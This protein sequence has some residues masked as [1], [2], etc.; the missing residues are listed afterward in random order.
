MSNSITRSGNKIYVKEAPKEVVKPATSGD[1]SEPSDTSIDSLLN[2][3][4]QQI[5]GL[6][7]SI[8][9]EVNMGTASR[10]TV[11]NLKDIMTLLLELKKKEKEFLDDMTD[12]ELERL[13][14]NANK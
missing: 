12:D 14:K 10:E 1:T 4:L 13:A 8:T 2:C 5:K 7:R 11:Q 9:A 3:G 6:M